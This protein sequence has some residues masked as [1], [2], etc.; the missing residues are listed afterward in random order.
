MAHLLVWRHVDRY[1]GFDPA[2][3]AGRAVTG[4][5]RPPAIVKS[6]GQRVLLQSRPI[7]R[8]ET[9]ADIDAIKQSLGLL[10]RHL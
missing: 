8:A 6:T 5:R 3:N 4:L 10:R 1:H 7:M 9:L 2:S